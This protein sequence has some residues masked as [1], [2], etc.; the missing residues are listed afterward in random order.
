MHF[1]HAA[2]LPE[3]RQSAKVTTA[4]NNTTFYVGGQRMNE[5]IGRPVR[6]LL[7]FACLAAGSTSL[8]GPSHWGFGQGYL[9]TV[10]KTPVGNRLA[11]YEAPLRAKNTNWFTRWIDTSGTY[12]NVAPGGVAVGDFWPSAFGTAYLAVIEQNG[13]KAVVKILAPPQVF[14]TSAWPIVGSAMLDIPKVAG[15]AAGDVLGQGR[16]QL[17]VL[18]DDGTI[19]IVSAPPDPLGEDW[20][21]DKRLKLPSHGLIKGFCVGDF[22]GE[23][24]ARIA[25]A[26]QTG[27]RTEIRFYRVNGDAL[28]LEAT[29]AAADLPRLAPHG[30]TAGDYVK[31]GFAALTL[32]P[33]NPESAIQLRVAPARNAKE[34]HNPGFIYNG[35]ALSRQWLPGAGGSSS[36]ITM[37]A[38]FGNPDN[39]FQ[40][41]RPKATLRPEVVGMAAGSL[42]GYVHTDLTTAVRNANEVSPKP[43]A[44][45]AFCHRFPQYSLT[46]GAP[47][48]GW[49]SYG[50]D[51]GYEINIKNNGRTAIPAGTATLKVWLNTP[52]RNADTNGTTWDK[53]DFVIPIDEDLPAFDPDNPTYLVKKVTTKWP[54]SLIPSGPG[55]TWKKLNLAEVGERWLVAVL[56]VPGEDN[57]RNNRFEA[58]LHAHTLHP[59]W[60]SNHSLADRT[61]TVGGDPASKENLSCKL[62]DAITCMW[63]RSGTTANEDVLQRVYFDGYE[64]GWPGD[65]P[66]PAKSQK[67]KAIQDKYEGWRELDAWYGENQGWERFNWADGAAELHEAGHLFHP[68]GDLYQYAVSPTTTGTATMA[69][70]TPAQIATYCWGPDSFSTN[71]A[72]IGPPACE[73]LRR[74]VVGARNG[75]PEAW[76]ELAPDKIWIRVLDRKRKPVPGAKVA[77]WPLGDHKPAESGVTG[78]DGRWDTGLPKGTSRIDRFG[79]KHYDRISNEMSFV[80]TVGLPGYQQ[81]AVLG[82]DTIASHGRHTIMYH[83]FIDPAGWTWDMRTNYEASAPKPAFTVNAAVQGSTVELGV[84]GKTGATYKVYRRWEPAYLRTLVGLFKADAPLL[85]IFQNMTAADSHRAGRFRA[86]Y[87]VTQSFGKRESL[88]VAV[89]VTG[90]NNLKGVTTTTKD[91]LIVAAN[92]GIANPFGIL[93]NGTTPYQEL[94]YHYRFGHTA[95][96]IVPSIVTPGRYYATLFSSDMRPDYRFDIIDPPKGNGGYDVRNDIGGFEAVSASGNT[97]TVG[98]PTAV[99]RIHP[100]DGVSGPAGAATVT[101]IDGAT[102]TTDKPIFGESGGRLWFSA[103]RLA[104]RPGDRADLRELKDARGLAAMTVGGKEY[105]VIADTGN[106]RVTIWDSETAYVTH[107]D[108]P[109]G[110]P[111]AVAADPSGAGRFFVLDRRADGQSLIHRYAFDRAAITEITGWPQRVGVSDSPGEMGLAVIGT[112]LAVTDGARGSVLEYAF[113]D[114]GLEPGALYTKPIGTF[115]GPA[116]L[117]H[118][119]DVAYASVGTKP[120]LYAVDGGNRMVRLK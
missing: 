14:S 38:R 58:A 107:V 111:A 65:L 96:K 75:T 9:A 112:S 73:M 1:C 110:A 35:R 48:Y 53:P 52:F 105:V 21:V 27:K 99:V 7:A 90:L 8:A 16:D 113:T 32:A 17:L 40:Q 23:H 30:L 25:I 114:S 116:M 28:T 88:P 15:T 106:S 56:D 54:Y 5:T 118:P 45:I 43:D 83:S 67:W 20:T 24:R 39:D 115:A 92:S 34:A 93:C 101:A 61:P 100:G 69:D 66:E 46:A 109:G 91:T 68:L 41:V 44:E 95:N 70:G 104:G 2:A 63:E 79:V 18:S 19:S 31:D 3:A 76:W 98:N 82:Q 47:N 62:A 81:S 26:T 86:T 10:E 36:K 57:P 50:E 51:M 55:A 102:L 80:V 97:I 60:R 85:K 13:Q 49:P 12:D 71:T 29:D 87:E 37:T 11:V 84:S 6:R 64:V 108:I 94:F 33:L 117:I 72:M 103:T 4:R 42:F 59:I 74:I 89:Q 120:A 119:T 78:K 77:L 22:W